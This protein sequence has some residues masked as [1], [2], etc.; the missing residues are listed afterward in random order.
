MTT[1][2]DASSLPRMLPPNLN[3]SRS[4]FAGNY[5]R[6]APH[7][8]DLRELVQNTT[9]LNY[10]A[11]ESSRGV[12]MEQQ[13]ALPRIADLWT[14]RFSKR[15][16]CHAAQYLEIQAAG[17]DRK[18]PYRGRYPSPMDEDKDE[19]VVPASPDTRWRQFLEKHPWRTF[20]DSGAGHDH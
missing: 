5:L 19:E 6:F 8:L 12:Q 4:V 13:D 9:R 18:Q 14:A 7:S 3:G 15:T 2:T 17:D 16:T 10:D 11:Y 20:G 1:Y